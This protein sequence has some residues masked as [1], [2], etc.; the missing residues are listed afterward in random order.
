MVPTFENHEIEFP[1]KVFGIVSEQ[2]SDSIQIWSASNSQHRGKATSEFSLCA[3][4]SSVNTRCS[5]IR[6]IGIEKS[7]DIYGCF[8]SFILGVE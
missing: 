3:F 6:H 7:V 4:R 2:L 1:I 5:V 8:N